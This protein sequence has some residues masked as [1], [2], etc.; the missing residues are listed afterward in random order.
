MRATGKRAILSL[1][2]VAGAASLGACVDEDVVFDDRPGFQDTATEAGGFV[3]YADPSSDS[4]QTICGACHGDMQ[5]QWEATAHASAWEG[6]QSSDHAQAVCEACHTVNSLGN[7]VAE[8]MLREAVGGH[9]AAA[10]EDGRYLDVQCESCHGP[11]LEHV[12]GPTG[13]NVPLAPV[14]TGADLSFGCGECHQGFH[15]PFVEE[16]ELSDHANLTA[17]AAENEEGG[18]YSCHSGEG[19]LQRLGVTA[20]Y[21]E[22]TDLLGSEEYAQI[23][24]AVCHDPHGSPNAS[25]LRLPVYT[26]D[27]NSHLCAA[28]HDRYPNPDATPPQEYLR[29]HSPSAG[30]MRGDAGWFPAGTGIQPGIDHPHANAERLCAT[31]H[32][33][34]SQAT[35]AG[36]GEVFHSQGHRF[37]AAPCVDAAGLPLAPQGCALTAEARAFVGCAE[38]HGSEDEAVTLLRDAVNDLLPR[39]RALD[40]RLTQIDPNRTAPGGEID[41]TDFRFTPAE[42]AYFNLTVALSAD[43]L[44][45]DD[46]SARVALASALTHNPA[47]IDALIDASFAALDAAYAPSALTAAAPPAGESVAGPVR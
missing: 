27:V 39:V 42:G 43:G 23:T 18:C 10:T 38:C 31:C 5:A 40:A 3:G 1:L 22:K 8:P 6:L 28:C 37:L 29:T 26:T 30:L 44:P 36:T 7:V 41:A 15:H 24:C 11:G 25:Q 4:K 14:E 19:G 12:L 9:A 33:A 45:A 16:W 32:V 21:L 47:L 13:A 35:D 20:D 34:P 2:L 17:F 46:E